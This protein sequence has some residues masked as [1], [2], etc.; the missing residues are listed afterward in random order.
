MKNLITPFSIFNF[1]KIINKNLK[2]NTPINKENL[3]HYRRDLDSM[4]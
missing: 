2:D 1:K 3:V 4:G